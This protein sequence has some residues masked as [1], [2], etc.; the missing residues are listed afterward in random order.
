[1]RFLLLYLA[2]LFYFYLLTYK[3]IWREEKDAREK[4]LHY[5]EK[6]EVE[7]AY[8]YRKEEKHI[9]FMLFIFACYYIIITTNIFH[10]AIIYYFILHIN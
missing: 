3:K 7:Y 9:I 4:I 2:M 10:A 6:A 8:W 5:I 1:M